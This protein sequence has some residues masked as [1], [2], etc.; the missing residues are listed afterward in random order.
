MAQVSDSSDTLF[1]AGIEASADGLDA[2]SNIVAQLPEQASDFALVIAQHITPGYDSRLVDL[3]Q[4]KTRWKVQ[5]AEDQHTLEAHNIYIIPTGYKPQFSNKTIHLDKKENDLY[6]IPSINAFFTSLAEGAKER[7]IGIII[8]DTGDD[9]AAGVPTNGIEAIKKHGGYVIVHAPSEAEH[10]GLPDAAIATGMSDKISHHHNIATG[11]INFTKSFYERKNAEPAIEITEQERAA[12]AIESQQG[13]IRS[14]VDQLDYN[15]VAVDT[16][17]RVIAI[18]QAQKQ[19]FSNLFQASIALGDN[20]VELLRKY[21]DSPA[22][23][24]Q[25]FLRTFDGEK[26]SID[27]YESSRTNPFGDLRCYDLQ[28]V[29]IHNQ[30]GQV[31]GGALSSREVTQKTKTDKQLQNI[32]K[33][34][35]NLTGQEFFEDLTDQVTDLFHVKYAYVGLL[36][37]DKVESEHHAGEIRTTALR[38]NGRLSHNFYYQLKGSP[39]KLVTQ[40]KEIKHTKNVRQQFP[41]DQ[42][43]KR[44]DAQSYLGVPIISPISNKILGILAMIHDQPWHD[45]PNVK[46]ILTILTLRAGAELE[47]M[48]AEERFQSKQKQLDTIASNISDVIFEAIKELDDTIHFTY[49]SQ[50]IE[51]FLEVSPAEVTANASSLFS[52]VHPDEKETLDQFFNLLR[53]NRGSL[54]EQELRMISRKSG[55]TKWVRISA[56]TEQ[57]PDGTVIG[58]GTFSDITS[59]K[60]FEQELRKAKEEAE[61][62]ARVKEEFLA[63]M[64][65]E[66]RTPLNAVIGLSNLLIDK[67][68]QSE[69]EE[70]LLR[71]KFS[72]ENLL[73]LINDILDFSKIEAGKL[74][75][76]DINFNLK[77]L[78]SNIKESHQPGAN[79]NNNTF[80]VDIDTKLP[81]V[82]KGDQVKLVQVINNLISNAMKFTKDG[83]VSLA[84]S[85]EKEDEKHVWIRFSVKDTGIGISRDKLSRIFEMFTQADN[86]TVRQ[87]GGTGL[88]LS[89]TKKLLELM[90]SEIHVE[91]EEDKGSLFY[92]I[93]Q[94]NRG[95]QDY[96][97]EVLANDQPDSLKDK[98]F[99]ILIVEDVDINRIILIQY[100]N[101]WWDFQLDE[102]TNGQEAIDKAEETNYDLIL[103]DIRMP[104]IDGYEATRH[105]RKLNKHYQAVPIIALTADTVQEIALQQGLEE[106]TFNDIVTKPFAPNELRSKIIR[107][108]SS[109][110][111]IGTTQPEEITFSSSFN[112]S[113]VESPFKHDKDRLIEFYDMTIQSLQENLHA[114]IHAMENRDSKA[115][116]AVNHKSKTI[117]NLFGLSELQTAFKRMEKITDRHLGDRLHGDRRESGAEEEALKSQAQRLINAYCKEIAN[118]RQVVQKNS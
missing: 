47:R 54:Y 65:H 58:Y 10:I 103:M 75:I 48:Q 78:I 27:G 116:H 67:N 93:I 1:I 94:L 46:S 11:I 110:T 56:K 72:S 53:Q 117:F 12:Q 29:P 39:C 113:S 2:L 98:K 77:N 83:T 91:S 102:A 71:L 40:N 16:C 64:S 108:L 111:H 14:V 38:I 28:W 23:T 4:K 61:K 85:L 26:I 15:I 70:N 42:K 8:S 20:I 66:I 81:E 6:T 100:L 52:T 50:S 59:L 69:L 37:H 55:H 63:T 107:Q 80:A 7:A 41:N 31:I 92:F 90:D 18:N 105:I 104:E 9:G 57:Q 82:V 87:F 3:L 97:E 88:G 21:P 32:L 106:V 30:G 112:F 74:E 35:A 17:F 79:K 51:R 101:T 62:A 22:K 13:T 76:E 118:R 43:L 34:S 33:R 68:R 89:I 36:K 44:W 49:I 84:L 25:M 99:K 60:Q 24:E 73:H 109:L 95:T 19:E 115:M 5:Y 114:A 96:M 86:S 45:I